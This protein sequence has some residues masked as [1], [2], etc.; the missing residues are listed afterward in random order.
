MPSS[1]AHI[2]AADGNQ[3]AIDYLI[4]G[5]DAYTAWIVTIA[6]YKALHMIEAVLAEQNPPCHNVDHGTRNDLLKKTR[7][8][9]QLWKHY[10]PLYQ[11]SLVARYLTSLGGSQPIESYLTV[12]DCKNKILNHRLRQIAMTANNLIG[13]DV[14]PTT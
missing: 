10:S 3:Q 12:D 2:K 4:L 11:A 5:G 8:Y 9:Q 6:F 1:A 13:R 7:K 14:F